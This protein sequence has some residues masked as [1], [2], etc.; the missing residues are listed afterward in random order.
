MT[1][2]WSGPRNVFE[3]PRRARFKRRT[4]SLTTASSHLPLLV[5]R[6]FQQPRMALADELAAVGEREVERHEDVSVA[7]RVG[8]TAR[9]VAPLDQAGEGHLG[10]RPLRV[11]LLEAGPERRALGG[12]LADGE[13]VEQLE[14]PRVAERGGEGPGALIGVVVPA[15]ADRRGPAEDVEPPPDPPAPPPPTPP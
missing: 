15:L 1:A 5:A 3:P 9:I 8:R 14:P 12:V 10:E 2:V 4:S 6:P 7:R 11:G 13:G